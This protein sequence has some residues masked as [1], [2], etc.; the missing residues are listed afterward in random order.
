MFALLYKSFAYTTQY[1]AL[2]A[3]YAVPTFV[4]FVVLSYRES[5]EVQNEY[6]KSF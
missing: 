3:A 2:C 1:C 5:L 4:N 6:K